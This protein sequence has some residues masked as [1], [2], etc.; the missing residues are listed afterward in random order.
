MRG[1]DVRLLLQHQSLNQV[2][3]GGEA[4]RD[5]LCRRLGADG[6]PDALE[7]LCLAALRHPLVFDAGLQAAEQIE[8]LVYVSRGLLLQ[9]RKKGGR[10]L[11]HGDRDLWE[12]LLW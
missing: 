2:T 5:E 11:L 12:R 4:R 10:L 3:E 6:D 7:D 1:D 8:A 9:R